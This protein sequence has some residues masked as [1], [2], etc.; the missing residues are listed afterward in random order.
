[1]KKIIKSVLALSSCAL[2]SLGSCAKSDEPNP[3]LHVIAN[4]QFAPTVFDQWLKV[5]YVDA[6][7]IDYKYKMEDIEADP[8]YNL[9]PP[10]LE[11][12][13]K[14]AKLVRHA[15]IGAYDEVAG[16]DF[17][18][19]M[20]PRA[21]LLIGSSGRNSDR[22]ELLG[23][24]EGGVR[25]TLYKVNAVN[26]ND[27]AHLNLYY[28]HT[29]HHEFGHILHQNK[30]WPTEYN[31][32]SRGDYL[33]ST[34]FQPDNNKISIY[35]PKGFVTAYSRKNS[36]E[37][38][39]EV[40]ACYITYTD[41]QWKQIFDAAGEAGRAKLDRKIKIVKDYMKDAW[42]I[43]MDEL[44]AVVT[45]RTAEV[46]NPSF[47]LIDPEWLPLLDNSDFRAVPAAVGSPQ[48]ERMRSA[49]L[50]WVLATP[51]LLEN[52]PT[53]QLGS[54]GCSLLTQYYSHPHNH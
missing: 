47:S 7:N 29:M 42:N 18:R 30:L 51:Y 15:W 8:N 31:D 33:A 34:F 4:R 20:S 41:E 16:I 9:V 38:F 10:S 19:L 6:Y 22:S 39:T 27:P 24:A 45:R 44:R 13:M 46:R 23:T 52:R 21:V 53:G 35:A 14:M 17:M 2:L 11:N 1:M 3:D 54:Y 12:S 36:E 48:E 40:T 32:I 25:V 50:D 28:F 26:V 43:D 49:V 5:N 37:D